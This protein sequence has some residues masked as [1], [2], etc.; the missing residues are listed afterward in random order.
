MTWGV[1]TIWMDE[2]T[3]D[4]ACVDLMDTANTFKVLLILQAFFRISEQVQQ[5]F[6]LGLLSFFEEE[7][8]SCDHRAVRIYNSHILTF[9]CLN[10]SL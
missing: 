4:S 7:T 5:K 10:Q 6:V 3:G 8:G 1:N 2:Q 9:K